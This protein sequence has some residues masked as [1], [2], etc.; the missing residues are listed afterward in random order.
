MSSQ[1][2]GLSKWQSKPQVVKV[3][4]QRQSELK[5]VKVK[6]KRLSEQQIHQG[7]GEGGKQNTADSFIFLCHFYSFLSLWWNQ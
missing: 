6:H 4:I 5:V 1:P 3:K 2:K 7:K